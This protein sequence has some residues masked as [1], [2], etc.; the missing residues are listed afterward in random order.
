MLLERRV[1]NDQETAN[2]AARA[3][4]QED[5]SSRQACLGSRVGC[6]SLGCPA[7]ETGSAAPKC[8][9]LFF[10]KAGVIACRYPARSRFAPPPG[11]GKFQLMIAKL[12]RSE[13]R[14]KLAPLAPRMATA[15]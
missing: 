5:T 1:G 2:G 13:A 6:A 8:P 12:P 11:S 3:R 15:A 4:E 9:W 14:L 10:I 7:N